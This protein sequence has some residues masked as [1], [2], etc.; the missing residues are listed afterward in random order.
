MCL[1]LPGDALPERDDSRR[2]G[3]GERLRARDG[4]R[5]GLRER[6]GVNARDGLLLL[7]GVLCV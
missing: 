3:L 6:E 2:L 1:D 7:P 5:D 4:E